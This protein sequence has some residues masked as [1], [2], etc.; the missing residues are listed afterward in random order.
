MSAIKISKVVLSCLIIS[1]ATGCAVKKDFY[2]IGGSRSDGTVDLA[3]DFKQFE[4]P[5]LNIQQAQA[6]ANSKCGVWGYNNAEAFGGKTVSCG[7]RSGFGDCIA[8]QV[9]VKY[10]CLGNLNAA[11][12][13]NAQKT[14]ALPTGMMTAEQYKQNQL[15]QLQQQNL[16]YEEY[17]KR[18][19]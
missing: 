9:I 8:G 10:Q 4:Q 6:L 3:Y 15:Q 18:Y 7:Q 17:Q 5:V 19:L 1:L 14:P 16:P 11:S 13:S 12:S 2:A